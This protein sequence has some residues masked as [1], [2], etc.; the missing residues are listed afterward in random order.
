[1]GNKSNK[2]KSRLEARRRAFDGMVANAGSGT[3]PG[4]KKV[5]RSNGGA[6]DHHRPGS[7]KK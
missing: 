2:A 3:R 6:H 7:N 1:M 5:R 4:S